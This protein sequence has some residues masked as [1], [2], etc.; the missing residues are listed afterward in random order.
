MIPLDFVLGREEAAQLWLHAQHVEEIGGRARAVDLFDWIA[1]Q[2]ER[3]RTLRHGRECR[4]YILPLPVVGR[5]GGVES[6][7]LGRSVPQIDPRDADEAVALVERQPAEDDGIH[8]RE[9]G[10]GGAYPQREHRHDD[11]SESAAGGKA[12]TRVTEIAAQGIEPGPA[13]QRVDFFELDPRIAEFDPRQA[14]G[15]FGRDPALDQILRVEIEVGPH[16]VGTFPSAG[17]SRPEA[18]P[19]HHL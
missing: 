3:D 8:D 18:A 7:E 2:R 13:V 15:L 16:L 5:V 9:D 10:R 14:P 19:P 6:R 1:A 17:V 11:S 4:E 12:A